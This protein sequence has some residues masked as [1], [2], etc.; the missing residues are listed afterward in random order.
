LNTAGFKQAID[1]VSGDVLLEQEALKLDQTDPK[2]ASL[3]ENYKDGIYYF[4]LQQDEVWNKLKVDST[5][6]YNY[7]L[8]NKDKY[9]WSD[10]VEFK[11]IFSRS[12]SAIYHY[13]GLLKQGENF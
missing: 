3:M 1:K 5:D 13:Y 9:R 7:F 10:R 4:K 12:D 2:F 11:E 6:L 8:A